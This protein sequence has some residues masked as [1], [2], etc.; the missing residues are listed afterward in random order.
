MEQLYEIQLCA[1]LIKTIF[2]F[3]C[4]NCKEL[5]IVEQIDK[6][7]FAHIYDCDCGAKIKIVPTQ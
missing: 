1:V 2:E 4:P 7:V 3:M 5:I 6:D